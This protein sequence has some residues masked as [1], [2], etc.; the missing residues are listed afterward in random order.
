[1]IEAG[2]TFK[3]GI[4]DFNTRRMP[5]EEAAAIPEHLRMFV[6]DYRQYPFKIGDQLPQGVVWFSENQPW[7]FRELLSNPSKLQELKDSQVLVFSGS[8]M[9]AFKFQEGKNPTDPETQGDKELLETA[10]NLIKDSLGEGKWVLGDCFGGQLGIH[11]IRGKLGR[12][13]VNQ[14]GNAVTEAGYL[15]HNLT[16]AGKN[17]E[18]FSTLPEKF[19]AAHFHSD[20]VDA[21]PAVG[22]KIQTQTGELEVV[23]SEVLA[24]RSGF[25]GKNGP[26][27]TEKQYIHAAVVEFNNGARLY[28]TQFHPE[29]S[30]KERADFFIR[31]VGWWLKQEDQMGEEYTALARKIPE[32]AD[33]SASKLFANFIESYKKHVQMEYLVAA[34]PAIL[35]EL[36]R[37]RID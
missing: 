34:A 22:A 17:D 20:F 29:M 3:A 25:Q 1:M 9:S 30:T 14:Y 21:L 31:N 12:L 6:A 23:R 24:T 28:H 33:Y 26:E 4:V 15:E 8:G 2:K 16:E 10:E 7:Y 35:G 18:V 36:Q 13:P 27:N 11:A 32:D 5:P 19:Y 37:F